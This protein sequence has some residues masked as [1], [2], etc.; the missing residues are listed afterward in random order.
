MYTGIAAIALI[1][2]LLCLISG[3][4]VTESYIQ[5]APLGGYNL[6]LFLMVRH[7]YCISEP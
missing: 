5:L 4:V 7:S 6:N 1:K 2:T 3:V